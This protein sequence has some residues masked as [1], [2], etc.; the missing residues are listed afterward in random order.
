MPHL[1][2][3]QIDLYDFSS[4][5][6]YQFV[7]QGIMFTDSS[8]YLALYPMFNRYCGELFVACFIIFVLYRFMGAHSSI[9]G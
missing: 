2:W 4:L 6:G 7:Y 3:E 9:V 1:T 5:S 8:I